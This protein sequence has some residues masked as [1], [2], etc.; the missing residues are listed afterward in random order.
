VSD[1]KKTTPP[2]S[3]DGGTPAA[4]TTGSCPCPP[5]PSYDSVDTSKELGSFNCAGLAHRTY[6]YLSLDDAKKKLAAGTKLGSC[7]EKCTKCKV[8]HWLWEWHD[9]SL[10]FK[11]AKGRVVATMKMP[12][13]FHTVSG[14]VD[15][16]VNQ[17]SSVYS[18]NGG[19]PLEGPSAPSHWRVKTGDEWTE[20]A[21]TNRPLYMALTPDQ[22]SKAGI[23]TSDLYSGSS[24]A[25]GVDMATGTDVEGSKHYL[26]CFAR[27][28]KETQ[29][30]YCLDCK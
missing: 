4:N 23:S 22:I 17:P 28:D 26:K 3:G 6:T 14:R 8:K 24:I 15:C 27:I 10:D 13:D 7:A 18:K 9:W 11:D 25:K 20:N 19:R 2:S 5:C 29:T 12:P 21:A 30:C 1:D 16:D